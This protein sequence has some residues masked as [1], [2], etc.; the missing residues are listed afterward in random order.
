M[1]PKTKSESVND[2][3]HDDLRFRV[4]AFD[5]GHDPA[6]LGLA[7]DIHASALFTL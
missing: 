7:E 4:L 2:G 1:I 6:S 5:P 3:T